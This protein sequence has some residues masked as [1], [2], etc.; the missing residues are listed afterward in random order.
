MTSQSLKQRITDFLIKYVPFSYIKEEDLLKL[1]GTCK[2]KVVNQG[3]FIFREGENPPKEFYVIHQGSVELLD[4]KTNEI[5]EVLEEGDLFGIAALLAKRSYIFSAK[6][7]EDTILYI[8]SYDIFYE[9]IQKYP[10]V[11]RFF[12]SGFAPGM[13]QFKKQNISFQ[14]QV[15]RTVVAHD[16]VLELRINKNVITAKP[17]ATVQEIA[18]IMTEKNIGSM[19]IAD[20]E[21]RPLG[22][23]TDSDLRKKIATGKFPITAKARDIMS[24][25]VF[26]LPPEITA[27]EAII[28]MM[29]RNIRHLVLTQDGTNQTPIYGIVSEHDLLVLHGNNPAVLVKEVQSISSLKTDILR[30][31][32]E[33]T[34]TL[35]K[36]YLEQDLSL[37]FITNTITLIHDNLIEKAIKLAKEKLKEEFPEYP[38]PPVK[39]AW[40][41]MGSEGRKEQTLR[42]DQD[43]AIIYEDPQ[44]E[45]KEKIQKYFLRMGELVNQFLVDYG[46]S[47]CP[48]NIM[49]RNPEW[50]KPVS[51]WKNY[52]RKWI[53]VPAEKN[54]LNATIFFDFRVAY[55]DESLAQELRDVIYKY[56]NPF[57]LVFLAKEA[58][59]SAPPLNFFRNFIVEKSGEHKNE[60]DLKG[61]SIKPLVDAARVLAIDFQ[62]LEYSSTIER[63][64]KLKEV[65]PVNQHIYRDAI[66][67]FQLYLKLRTYFG[68]KNQD[69]GRYIKPEELS[70]L[71]KQMLKNSFLAIENIQKLLEARY[72]LNLIRE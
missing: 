27:T 35:I 34:D 41:S 48:A 19:I 43:N 70:K 28:Q 3:E 7:T 46:F 25:P 67:S 30:I 38:Q 65:D 52:F 21:R 69:S 44:E 16:E 51:V 2:I 33:K 6:A 40:L 10:R 62:I 68:F 18:K 23:I 36:S 15:L 61:R 11:L 54:L 17:D 72:Q 56:K 55:G 50:C 22:I 58:A 29:K 45:D 60:F 24:A 20:E 31:I 63:Y 26:T 57:F 64:E 39:F 9:Y 8:L 4:E 59:T 13:Q 71:E 32:R 12:S 42:T 47:E 37:P 66:D 1:A 14:D 53:E 49:A 5:I